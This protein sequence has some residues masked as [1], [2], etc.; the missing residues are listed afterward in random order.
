M[1]KD[2]TDTPILLKIAPDME[3]SQAVDLTATAVEAGAAG[4][5]ATN[6]SIDYSLLKGAKNFG[7]ISGKVIKEKSFTIFEA[8]AKEL[9]GKCT[10]ISVGGVD[11]AQEAYRRIKA[12]ANLVQ[13]YTAFIYGGPPLLR[14]I[15]QGLL[16]LLQKDGFDTISQAVGADRK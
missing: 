7:G 2:L 15:N 16:Q 14:S 5:I 9:F 13:L 8:I 12:G 11:S 1:A 6:T 3:P 10:L 4:I